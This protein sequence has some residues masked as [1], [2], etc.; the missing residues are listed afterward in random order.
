MNDA[1]RPPLPSAPYDGYHKYD[2][3]VA[4]GYDASRENED[5]WLRENEFVEAYFRGR[6]VGSLL[7]LPVGTGRFFRYYADVRAVTGVDISEAMLAEARRKATV[8]S[9]ETSLALERGDVFALRFMD[10][11][12][13]VALVMRLFHLIPQHLL[14]GAVNELCRVTGGEIILQTYVPLSPWRAAVQRVAARLKHFVRVSPTI[15]VPDQVSA[16]PWSHIQAFYHPQSLVDSLFR[17]AGFLPGTSQRL[18][19]YGH[20]EVRVTTYRRQRGAGKPAS[21]QGAGV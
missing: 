2:D 3:A 9:S 11:E 8:F 1:N 21:A 18:A 5:H 13:D 10:G 12:F 19:V 14:A 16:T 7:D 20:A 17:T 15:G 6:R 4:Q